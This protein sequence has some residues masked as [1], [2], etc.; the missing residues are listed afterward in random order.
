MS[1]IEEKSFHAGDEVRLKA[2]SGAV[3]NFAAPEAARFENHKEGAVLKPA[4]DTKV[5]N[6]V[7]SLCGHAVT[8]FSSPS[9]IGYIPERIID[10]M[11]LHTTQTHSN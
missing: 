8:P 5:Y 2:P 3:V 4:P 7:C 9:L 10:E 6:Y 11:K 1:D